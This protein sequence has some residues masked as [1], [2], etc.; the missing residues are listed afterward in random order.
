MA[1]HGAMSKFGISVIALILVTALSSAAPADARGFFGLGPLG[2]LTRGLFHGRVHHRQGHTRRFENLLNSQINPSGT[3]PAATREPSGED[4]LTARNLFTDPDPR[5]QIAATAALDLRHDDRNAT[6]G[7]WSH[8]HG[9][10]GYA[11]MTTA[12][13]PVMQ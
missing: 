2:L 3:V 10:S 1:W 9:C 6:N 5:R 7:W 12:K 11:V 13:S 8:G 4:K